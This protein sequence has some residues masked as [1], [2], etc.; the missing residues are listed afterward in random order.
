VTWEQHGVKRS[1]AEHIKIHVNAAISVEVEVTH[2]VDAFDVHVVAVVE[3]EKAGKLT[4]DELTIVL[5]RPEPHAPIAR[6]NGITALMPSALLEC[7]SA[8]LP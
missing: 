8:I 6:E 7:K 2:G 4:S 5:V 1:Q 3:C